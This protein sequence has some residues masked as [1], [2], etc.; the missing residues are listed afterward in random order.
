M[1]SNPEIKDHQTNNDRPPLSRDP[2]T[3]LGVQGDNFEEMDEESFSPKITSTPN[4]SQTDQNQSDH[5]IPEFIIP[6]ETT[7]KRSDRSISLLQEDHL[8]SNTFSFQSNFNFDNRQTGYFTVDPG[9]LELESFS[10]SD[11]FNKE[12]AAF[13]MDHNFTFRSTHPQSSAPATVTSATQRT[14]QVEEDDEEWKEYFA[15]SDQRPA[16]KQ[17]RKRKSKDSNKENIGIK[18]VKKL[19]M[20]VNNY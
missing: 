13:E 19:I 5:W 8:K 3:H 9:P 16:E 4:N 14:Q 6:K 17:K 20:Y 1:Q 2:D 15:S 12:A 7:S 11:R 18:N 10:C